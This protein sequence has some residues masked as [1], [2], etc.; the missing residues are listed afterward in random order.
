MVSSGPL[1]LRIVVNPRTAI[2]RTEGVI[3]RRPY[4]YLNRGLEALEVIS[5][6]RF[7]PRKLSGSSQIARSIAET[8]G[9]GHAGQPVLAAQLRPVACL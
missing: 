5:R 1:L 7:L 6:L 3:F 2:V 4:R 8:P 9:A